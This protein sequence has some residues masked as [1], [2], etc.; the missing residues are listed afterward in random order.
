[1][2]EAVTPNENLKK[3]FERKFG[4]LNKIEKL[5]NEKKY[6]KLLYKMMKVVVNISERIKETNLDFL[7]LTVRSNEGLTNHSLSL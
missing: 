6:L 3:C 4:T 1:M 7:L 5:W 2:I